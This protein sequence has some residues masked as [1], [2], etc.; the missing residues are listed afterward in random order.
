MV[1]DVIELEQGD[2]VPAD[3]LAVESNE[4]STNESVLT[5]EP[6]A[7]L[8]EVLTNENYRHNPCPFLL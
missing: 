5:G 7:M 3:C 6:E 4:L 2:T 8:K 1:G